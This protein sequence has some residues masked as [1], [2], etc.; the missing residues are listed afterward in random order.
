MTDALREK[1]SKLYE[2]VKRGAT[3]G[4]RDAAKRVLDKWLDKHNL[5]GID[6]DSLDKPI[7]KF[8]YS[9][10]LEMWLLGS[11]IKYFLSPTLLDDARRYLYKEKAI[12]LP[13]THL[14]YI[15]V[16]CAYEYFRRH[17]RKQWKKTCEPEL[18]KCRKVNIRNKRRGQLQIAFYSSYVIASNLYKE[19][20][21][22][23][24]GA[25]LSK[26]ELDDYRSMISVEG[27]EYN[28]QVQSA[29]MLNEATLML[30]G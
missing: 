21:V 27:G 1:L 11:I 16:E 30:E 23:I 7:R 4:E 12:G 18:S 2:L 13:L 6:L 24:N 10:Q 9:S 15:T 26:Q 14:D 29:H 8:K 19:D 5:Q 28:T 17:M 20:L 25:E 22:E 3:E